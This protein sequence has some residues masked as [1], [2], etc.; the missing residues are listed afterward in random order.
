MRHYPKAAAAI[1]L[2][3]VTVVFALEPAGAEGEAPV[4][5]AQDEPLQPLYPLETPMRRHDVYDLK[6]RLRDLGYY[7]GPLDEVYDA[8]AVSAVKN[9]QKT[10][11]LNATGTVDSATWRALAH[12]VERPSRPAAGEMPPG[13]VSIEINTETLSL[14]LCVDGVP[15]RTYPVAA[16][17]W[18]TMTPV[19]E[20]LIIDKGEWV[21]TPFGSRWMA[22]DVPW[23]SYGIHGTNMPWTI[24]GYFSIG[25]VRM[26]NEDVEEI[27]NLVPYGTLVTVEGYVPPLNWSQTIGP[28]SAAPEVV[29]LQ[30]SLREMGFDAGRCDG[31]YGSSTAA[32]VEDVAL[33]YGL[34][35]GED[36]V[37]EVLRLLDLR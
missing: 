16:G 4:M 21:G 19:G 23:G 9:F 13:V 25:C 35:T 10:Y 37:S 33:L 29:A 18:E 6:A 26:Y 24:G 22:L 12:G 32:A 14:T 34:S 28:G 7:G 17:K 3:L 15:W 31:V 8:A 36:M 30:R 11:W 20:W 27:F 2:A 5:L 1:V